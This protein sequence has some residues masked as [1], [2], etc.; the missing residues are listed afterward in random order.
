M[1][2]CSHRKW[3][4]RQWTQGAL[5]QSLQVPAAPVEPA[6]DGDT[7]QIPGGTTRITVNMKQSVA[8][9]EAAATRQPHEC[10]T[11]SC[12]EKVEIW[13]WK[14][15]RV[16]ESGWTA[17][18]MH[19]LNSCG[20][21]DRCINRMKGLKGVGDGRRGW[22]V[23]RWIDCALRIYTMSPVVAHSLFCLLLEPNISPANRINSFFFCI[24]L[25]FKLTQIAVDTSAGPYKNYTVVF[26]GSDNG[27]VLKI[28]ASSEGA[29]ASFN[30]QL[31]EDIDVYNPNKLENTSFISVLFT[32]GFISLFICFSFVSST[33]SLFCLDQS[34]PLALWSVVTLYWRNFFCLIFCHSLKFSST[35]T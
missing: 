6:V 33:S 21:T 11:M 16:W 2:K 4:N 28:L 14:L 3:M 5:Q 17:W 24:P 8:A 25:R 1:S 10:Q 18:K 9:H 13:D 7:G 29:N 27:H 12:K 19:R 22:C 23:G 20:W 35:W 32:N 34:L 26:L 31:L 15:D 30:S